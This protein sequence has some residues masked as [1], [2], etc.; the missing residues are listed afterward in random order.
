MPLEFKYANNIIR[1]ITCLSNKCPS[2]HLVLYNSEYR[3]RNDSLP[4]ICPTLQNHVFKHGYSCIECL[5]NST[6]ELHETINK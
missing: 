5:I 1:Y 3:I 2:G 4:Y 6:Q